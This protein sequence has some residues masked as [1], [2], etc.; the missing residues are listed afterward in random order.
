MGAVG[1]R[2]F[3]ED[4]D[5][6]FTRLKEDAIFRGAAKYYLDTHYN[7]MEEMKGKLFC[8][9]VCLKIAFWQMCV[10]VCESQI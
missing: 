2:K 3:V 9:R 1:F 8:T 6:R 5:I 4:V 10:T 7:F